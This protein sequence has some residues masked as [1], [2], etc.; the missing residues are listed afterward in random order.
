MTASVHCPPH[1]LRREMAL[2]LYRSAFVDLDEAHKSTDAHLDLDRDG[3]VVSARC[4]GC[5]VETIIPS[6]LL[7][8]SLD[9]LCDV[10]LRP[11]ATQLIHQVWSTA[12]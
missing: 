2:L 1:L 10:Y 11:A 9:Q 8:L 12:A 4:N 3:V 6:Y 5:F 7:T